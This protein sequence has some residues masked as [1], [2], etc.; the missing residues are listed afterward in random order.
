MKFE[1][2][3]G[4]A[5][6]VVDIPRLERNLH[7]AIDGH[8]ISADAVEVSPGTY[9]LLI[10]GQSFEIRVEK[11]GDDLRISVGGSEYT[12]RVRDPRKWQRNHSA[13]Q[14][15]EARLKVLA[16][17]P[18][19]IVRVLVAQGDAVAAGQGLLV[20]EAMKMQNEIRSPKSGSV[21][22]LLVKEGQA[23]NAGETIAVIA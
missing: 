6:H 14:S 17:M 7:A 13:T 3:L 1:I 18:G 10:D 9:S 16:P 12:A 19:R 11:L 2:E 23:V 8:A 20:V 22:R 5:S 21:E 15:S 4:A